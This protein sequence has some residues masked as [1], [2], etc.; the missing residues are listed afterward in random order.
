MLLFDMDGTLID[1]SGIWLQI[2]LDFTTRHGLQHTKEYH[3]FVAHTSAP[4]AAQFTKEYYNLAD[5]VESIMQEWNDQALYEYTHTIAAK[6]AVKAY[7]EQCRAGGERM[8]ILTSCAPNLCYAALERNALRAYFEQVYFAQEIGIEKSDPAL[9]SAVAAR[10]GVQP[11]ACTLYDDSPISCRSA[12]RAGM[13]VIAVHDALFADEEA[14]LRASCDG[15][16]HS[17]GELL[18]P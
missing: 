11:E 2:D 9:F 3:D 15:Y 12:K 1:S 17:F 13:R 4:T 14:Q 5:S 16:I 6:P 18:L 7:L 8:A 10:M